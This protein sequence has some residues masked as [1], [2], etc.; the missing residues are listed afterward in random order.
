MP[1]S[2]ELQDIKTK[3]GKRGEGIN[4]RYTSQYGVTDLQEANLDLMNSREILELQ[5]NYDAGLGNGL[6]DA[7][8]NA[9]ANQTDTYWTDVFFRTGT[10]MSHDLAITSGGENSSN[11]TSIGYFDQD[12][13]FLNSNLKRFTIRN[14]FF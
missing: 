4:F 1:S 6:S 10:S 13:I 9:I 2:S 12:G 11:F 5:R 14:N 8:L 7:E 3:Q